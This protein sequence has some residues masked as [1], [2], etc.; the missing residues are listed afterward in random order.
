MSDAGR[1]ARALAL[2][3]A[4]RVEPADGRDT[5]P[6]SKTEPRVERYFAIGDPQAPARTFFA[7]LDAHGLLGDDGR[8]VDGA[9]LVSMGDHFDYAPAGADR[10]PLPSRAEL[11]ARGEEGVRILRWLCAHPKGRTL[12]LFGNHDACRVME[13]AAMTDERFARAQ[14]LA[15]E[16][17]AQK[18][19]EEAANERF[20]ESFDDVPTPG[21]LTKDFQTFSERQRALVREVLLAGRFALALVGRLADGTEALLTHAG[22]AR[23]EAELLEAPDAQPRTL[24]QALGALFAKQIERVRGDWAAGGRAPLDLADVH[25]PGISREEGGGLLYHRPSDPDRR[26]EEKGPAVDIDWE[27]AP[28]RPRRFHPK[29][30]PAGLTQV[31]AHTNHR[32]CLKELGKGWIAPGFSPDFEGVRTLARSEDGAIRYAPGIAEGNARMLL[33]DPAMSALA[34]PRACPLLELSAVEEA[35]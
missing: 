18:L 5:A 17:R 28:T 1:V 21:L 19:D 7:V 15:E 22:V 35:Q 29:D 10:L 31:C 4:A 3:D 12:V 8:L 33:L 2:A 27:F 20:A 34:D 32:K 16:L 13:L 23:R 14:A 11:A 30:L 26:R 24:A 6:A 25:V 9:G